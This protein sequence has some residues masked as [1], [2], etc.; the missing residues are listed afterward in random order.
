[1]PFPIAAVLAGAGVLGSIIGLFGKRK[2]PMSPEELKRFFGTETISKETLDLFNTLITSPVGQKMAR[3]AQLAGGRIS[4]NIQD[5]M[6]KAG[7]GGEGSSGMT[8]FAAATGAEAGTALELQG[9]AQTLAGALGSV[10]SNV[11]NR[12]GIAAQGRMQEA[13]TPTF[14]EKIGG[15]IT[16]GAGVGL[17]MLPAKTAP[18][19][20]AASYTGGALQQ[21]QNSMSTPQFLRTPGTPLLPDLGGYKNNALSPTFGKMFSNK[22]PYR[23]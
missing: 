10:T 7:L 1:M 2:T 19:G 22:S 16:G 12:M 20:G 8:S 21:F 13:Q 4:Q 18:A 11:N 3:D 17:S 23:F 15:A 5:R 9:R 14:A 6:A